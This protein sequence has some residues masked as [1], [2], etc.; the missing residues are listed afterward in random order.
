MMKER[1]AMAGITASVIF[2]SCAKQDPAL[3]ESRISFN[4][5]EPVRTTQTRSGSP[6]DTNSFI[7]TV[8]SVAGDIVYCGAYGGKPEQLSVKAGSYEVS[9]T[10]D[11]SDLPAFNNPV[12]GDS[13]IVIASNGEDVNVEFLCKMTN[14]GISLSLTDAFR[15]KYPAGKIVCAR[16]MG[17]SN[18]A[19]EKHA[20]AGSSPET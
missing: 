20:Q 16:M 3:R 14:A 5:A 19:T 4:F 6:F 8:R 13:Q 10:S 12:Y 1:L 9:V 15:T 7:L 2:A 11:I 18:T 17:S